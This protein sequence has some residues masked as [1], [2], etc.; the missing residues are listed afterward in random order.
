MRDIAM[1]DVKDNAKRRKILQ[2]LAEKD[3]LEIVK[4][5]GTEEAEAK[6]KEIIFQ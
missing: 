4:T 5:K 2:R 1:S 6:M 3:I